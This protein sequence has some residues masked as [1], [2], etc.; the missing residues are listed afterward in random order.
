[1]SFTEIYNFLRLMRLI[2]IGLV[3]LIFIGWLVVVNSEKR[4]TASH[5]TRPMWLDLVEGTYDAGWRAYASA[6]NWFVNS[7]AQ[8]KSP[9]E[10]VRSIIRP[11]CDIEVLDGAFKPY[12]RDV[13]DLTN[14]MNAKDGWEIVADKST[15]TRVW[16]AISDYSQKSAMPTCGPR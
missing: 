15:Q 12:H 6:F 1:M 7:G 10:V 5:Q 14:P 3:V 4:I 16:V 13:G 11:G 8:Q 9:T 2:F